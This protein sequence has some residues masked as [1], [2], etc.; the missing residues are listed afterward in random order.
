[1]R[2]WIIVGVCYVM[3]MG[4]LGVI[5]GLRTAGEAVRSWGRATTSVGTQRASRSP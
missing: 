3:G 5:G 1:M 2:D 4:L